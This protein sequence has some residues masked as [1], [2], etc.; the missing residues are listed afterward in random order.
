[1]ITTNAFPPFI[2]DYI[3]DRVQLHGKAKIVAKNS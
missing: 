3:A 1:M 2:L